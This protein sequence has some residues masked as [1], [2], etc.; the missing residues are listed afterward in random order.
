MGAVEMSWFHQ[1]SDGNSCRPLKSSVSPTDELGAGL[2][3]VPGFGIGD[4]GFEGAVVPF[5]AVGEEGVP[6]HPV[7]KRQI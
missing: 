6:P 3:F 5:G 7:K 4:S 1:L 2:G